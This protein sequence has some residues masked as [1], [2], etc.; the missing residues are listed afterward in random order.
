MLAPTMNPAASAFAS[1]SHDLPGVRLRRNG[2]A[3]RP[4]ARA[5]MVAATKTE[6]ALGLTRRTPIAQHARRPT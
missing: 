6:N 2:S 1:P 3:P 4:V 5:V